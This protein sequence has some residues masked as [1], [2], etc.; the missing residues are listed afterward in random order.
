MRLGAGKQWSG[1]R[2]EGSEESFETN[3]EEVAKVG[4]FWGE[5]GDEASLMAAEAWVVEVSGTGQE[6][7]E[8]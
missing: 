7:S 5:N 8:R 6:G 4:G 3:G 2:G 1:D